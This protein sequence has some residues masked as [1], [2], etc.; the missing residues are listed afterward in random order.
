MKG[1]EESCREASVIFER[2]AG[3]ARAHN[4]RELFYRLS[5]DTLCAAV[6]IENMRKFEFM[7]AQMYPE[8][9]EDVWRA[10]NDTVISIDE[11]SIYPKVLKS[12]RFSLKEE[13]DET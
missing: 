12:H 6:W 9:Y 10:V 5:L 2:M 7:C 11:S 3:K 4:N 13:N 1:F 8:C